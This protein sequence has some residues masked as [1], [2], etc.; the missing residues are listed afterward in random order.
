MCIKNAKFGD[1][2]TAEVRNSAGTVVIQYILKKWI[3]VEDDT[4]NT[5]IEI[6][7]TP[8]NARIPNSFILRVTYY[9]IDE[10]YN[11]EIL[12]NYFLTEKL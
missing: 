12:I 5:I 6:D 4:K 9:A 1:Y 3:I 8:L 7:T 11:R 10:G 2:I